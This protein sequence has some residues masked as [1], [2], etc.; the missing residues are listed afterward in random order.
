MAKKAE[1]QQIGTVVQQV[2]ARTAKQRGVL[3]NIQRQWG[4]LVGK[5][6]AGHTK[7]V[8]LLHG[9][10]IVHADRPGDAFALS[11]Q[12]AQ[13]LERLQ[14]TATERVEEIIIRP[15][16]VKNAIRS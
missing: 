15:G 4:G 3:A 6:L 5:A 2:L 8:S 7:P 9:R 10:L 14:A 13:L 1:A 11:Y 12:R 16:E